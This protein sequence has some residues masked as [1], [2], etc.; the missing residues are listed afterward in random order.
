MLPVC[1]QNIV[2]IKDICNPDAYVES[3]SGFDIF[4]APEI[5]M[6]IIGDLGVPEKMSGIEVLK[7]IKNNSIRDFSIDF[8][9]HLNSSGLVPNL[10]ESKT[11][12]SG[13]FNMSNQNALYAGKR[14]LTIYPVSGVNGIKKATISKLKI[15]P[16]QSGN[17]Q[18]EIRDEYGN[19]STTLTLALTADSVNEFYINY[20]ISGSYARLLLDNT[21]LETY[22]SEITCLK[23]CGGRTP[24][25]CGY[26]TGWDGVKDVKTEGF[27]MVAEF[28][29]TC[30]Y[31][32]LICKLAKSYVGK[33][34]FIKMR[35]NVIEHTVFSNRLTNWIIYGKEER[36]ALLKDL[37]AE[38][39]GIFNTLTSSLPNQLLT[40]QKEGCIDCRGISVKVNV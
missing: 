12:S 39:S 10:A 7:S 26:V 15:L 1:L 28:S 29:C 38:Y 18:L 25:P 14:G 19:L 8:I 16:K 36:A 34:L 4:D 3:T 6:G 21:A 31:S 30:D 5:N 13:N 40:Y 23:G 37:Q 22:S 9:S 32:S 33:L 17:F 27:G 35:M 2:S 24:N 20:P 11:I